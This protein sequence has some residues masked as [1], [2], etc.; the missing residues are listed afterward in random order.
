[1]AMAQSAPAPTGKEAINSLLN[2]K[3]QF[4]KTE[5]ELDDFEHEEFISMYLPYLDEILL[6]DD[7]KNQL[8]IALVRAAGYADEQNL[9]VMT[10]TLLENDRLRIEEKQNFYDELVINLGI[11]KAALWMR[12]EL[13]FQQNL[14]RVYSESRSLR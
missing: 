2:Q 14:M 13:V 6:L 1:M 10:G 8:Q 5:M 3:E 12:A 7:S 9:T 4:L 11:E